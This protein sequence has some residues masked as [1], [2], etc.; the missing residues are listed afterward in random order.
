MIETKVYSDTQSV[1][2]QYRKIDGRNDMSGRN[3][4]SANFDESE[5]DDTSGVD[6]P[7]KAGYKVGDIFVLMSIQEC[8]QHT[9]KHTSKK[10]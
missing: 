8:M 4:R 6:H 2:S 1:K 7:I 3:P 10:I 9:S 5:K